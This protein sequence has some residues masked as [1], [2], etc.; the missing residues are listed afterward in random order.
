MVT[1]G[2][3]RWLLRSTSD[4]FIRE[5]PIDG[6]EW[7]VG[8]EADTVLS[9]VVGDS[10]PP[11]A[12]P[13]F[14]L[15]R[16]CDL[17][18]RTTKQATLRAAVLEEVDVPAIAERDDAVY[19][20]GR[21]L[22]AGGVTALLPGSLFTRLAR[23]ERGAA[24]LGMTVASEGMVRIELDGSIPESIDS[25]VGWSINGALSTRAEALFELAMS[26]PNLQR[27][28]GRGLRALGRIIGGSE[29][30][31]FDAAHPSHALESIA[32]RAGVAAGG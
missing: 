23:V 27:V 13:V 15:Y 18:L 32:R 1:H 30:V 3:R 12:R 17:I 10:G 14:T 26:S 25:I 6:R 22:R 21:V 4:A 8:T 29:V 19:L 31:P 7:V 20:R 2:R 16:G 11:G 28:G 24:R 5:L 9:A